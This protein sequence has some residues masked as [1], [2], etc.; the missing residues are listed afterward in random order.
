LGRVSASSVVESAVQAAVSVTRTAN[1]ATIGLY[2]PGMSRKF[3][4]I[5]FCS[6]LVRSI[7]IKYVH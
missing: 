1:D 5:L 2:F 3:A 4:V 6:M 7:M